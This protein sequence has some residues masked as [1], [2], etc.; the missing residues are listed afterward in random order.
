[1][2]WSPNQSKIDIYFIFETPRYSQNGPFTDATTICYTFCMK[3]GFIGILVIALIIVILGV[4]RTWKT[5]HSEN[6]KR[7]LAGKVPSPLPSGIYKGSVTGIDVPWKGK[8]FNKEK[9]TGIN[10][11]EDNGKK[12]E[13]FPF[14][15]YIGKGIMDKNLDVF[16]IDYNISQNPFWLRIIL[17]EIVEVKKNTYLG[18]V[19]IVL[20]LGIIFSLGY[21]NLE[22]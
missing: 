20:P 9:Q 13:K 3:I 2:N 4:Q 18:K 12:I 19:H 5:E 7:F 14:K 10:V 11:L 16:K 8:S 17:D 22:K 21:F 6:E 1:M 15:T